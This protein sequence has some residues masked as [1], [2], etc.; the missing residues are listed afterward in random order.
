MLLSNLFSYKYFS[1]DEQEE[2]LDA[3]S[4]SVSLDENS[5][6]DSENEE[7]FGYAKGDPLSPVIRIRDNTDMSMSGESLKKFSD[8]NSQLLK[9]SIPK[10]NGPKRSR[11]SFAV[12]DTTLE[13]PRSLSEDDAVPPPS[14]S[15]NSSP[16]ITKGKTLNP[17]ENDKVAP[18]PPS[19]LSDSPLINKGTKRRPP[20]I[21]ALRPSES[22]EL[23]MAEMQSPIVS[24]RKTLLGNNKPQLSPSRNKANNLLPSIS[25]SIKS[26]EHST[27]NTN[28]DERMKN[29]EITVPGKTIGTRNFTICSF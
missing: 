6:D 4:Q 23:G 24:G 12:L 3:L 26:D 17:S 29:N 22:D 21:K 19:K 9:Q 15:P 2:V 10:S 27:N 18:P 25:D 20:G 5:D 13:R 28:T 7:Y 1:Q 14:G 16:L 11:P 8:S